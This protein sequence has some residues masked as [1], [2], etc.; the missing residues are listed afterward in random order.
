MNPGAAPCSK[1]S[2][3]KSKLNRLK[4]LSSLRVQATK[5]PAA[6]YIYKHIYIYV[7][8]YIY[9]H[10]YT[11]LFVYICMYIY[12]LIWTRSLACSAGFQCYGYI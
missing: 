9:I 7:Y 3:A 1:M 2:A 6:V 4:V 12:T 8:V 11:E 10:I 5:S